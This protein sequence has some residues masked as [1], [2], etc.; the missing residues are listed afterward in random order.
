MKSLKYNYK[1]Q[2]SE[3]SSKEIHYFFL[4]NKMTDPKVLLDQR[5]G[6]Q[7]TL[8]SVPEELELTFISAKT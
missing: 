7:N 1:T 4:F 2:P 6:L 3:N 5:T 8:V